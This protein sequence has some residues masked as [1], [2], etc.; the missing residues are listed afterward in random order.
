MSEIT[1]GN[2]NNRWQWLDSAKGIAI[3]AV[4]MAHTANF[5]F[6]SPDIFAVLVI[7]TFFMPLFFLCSGFVSI[8]L[9]NRS[10]EH[11]YG[12]V[13]KD[14]SLLFPLLF[15][16]AV[17]SYC[18][19]GDYTINGTLKRLFSTWSIGYWFLFVLFLFRIAVIFSEMVISICKIDR[20]KTGGVI[21]LSFVVAFMLGRL[22]DRWGFVVAYFPFF[23][24]GI[25]M[26]K[27]SLHALILQ[28]QW[29]TTVLVILAML[30]FVAYHYL[31]L[32]IHPVF[33]TFVVR[34]LVTLSL[35]L[36]CSHSGGNRLLAKIGSYSLD[37][38]CLH[39]F[40]IVGCHKV[41]VPE[42]FLLPYPW[43]VQT[44]LI[45]M[46]AILLSMASIALSKCISAVPNLHKLIFGR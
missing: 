7:D 19:T 37:I 34:G 32:S 15:C 41:L 17:Y 21:I 27:Y 29:G 40:F 43:A 20:Y 8:K 14:F 45:F 24:L 10:V 13:L 38:Y 6:A 46:V 33:H 42:D 25:I 12:I 22:T 36:A 16:G 26:R 31:D 39:Y 2:Q 1:L 35:F 18:I 44:L 3:F 11:R 5:V 9:L 28:Y 4:M 23:I 30:S